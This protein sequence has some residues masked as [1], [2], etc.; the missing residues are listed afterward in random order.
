MARD[1]FHQEVRE[2]LEKEGWKITDDPLYIK[3]GKI[4]VQID[5]GAE[6]IIGQVK[7]IKRDTIMTKV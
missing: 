2:A 5:L 1:K 7:R 6:L 4:P 3:V